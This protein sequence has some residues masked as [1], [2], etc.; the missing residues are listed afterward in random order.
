MACFQMVTDP[1]YVEW[2]T[3]FSKTVERDSLLYKLS[4]SVQN[5]KR[6]ASIIPLAQIK[7]TVHLIPKFGPIVPW[8]WA[9]SNVLDECNSFY[10]NCFTDR[11]TYV[12]LY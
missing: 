4:R 5:G 7:R 2:F 12:T 8:D 11:H 3:P 9:S 10:F 1:Q 6:L